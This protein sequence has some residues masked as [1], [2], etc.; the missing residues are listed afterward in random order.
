MAGGY[1]QAK[2]TIVKRLDRFCRSISCSF[3]IY[4]HV[5]SHVEYFFHLCKTLT[6]AFFVF[7]VHEDT[8]CFIN[9]SEQWDAGHFRFCNRF[10]STGN[11]GGRNGNVNESIV[12]TYYNI[13]F[14]L[15]EMMP[16]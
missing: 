6:P 16:A 7:P 4:T 2:G 1:G 3:G 14:P 11:T 15:Y 10:V 9:Q 12:I 8:A 13:S 5:K